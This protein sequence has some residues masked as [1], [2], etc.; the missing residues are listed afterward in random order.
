MYTVAVK[1][2]FIARHYLTGGD[3]GEENSP[4]AHHYV[5]E[6]RLE[7]PDLD[8]HGYLTDICDIESVLD[9][10]LAYF[11]DKILN[12]LPEFEG[13]NPSIEHFA[14][15]LCQTMAANIQTRRLSTMAV[16]LSENESAWAQYRKEILN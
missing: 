7:G 14:R 1:R 15:I 13:L 3:W 8:D 2:D 5:V 9:A 10:R 16:K 12:E 6:V 11:R 4:H